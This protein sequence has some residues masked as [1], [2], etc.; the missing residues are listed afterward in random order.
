[1]TRLILLAPAIALAAGCAR[2]PAGIQPGMWEYEV[3]TTAVDAPGLPAEALQQAQAGLNQPQ[4]NRECVTPDNAAN[5]LRE[6]RDQLTGSQGVTCQT[7]DDTFAGGVIRFRATCRNSA[8]T[9]AQLQLTLDGRFAATTLLADIAVDAEVVNPNGS[10]MQPVRTRG[11][12]KGRRI[13]SCA[14]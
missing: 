14:L 1:M 7:S 9:Q 12:V 4:R 6:V 8:G 10:G 11:T 13:G 2:A 5:P 3:T